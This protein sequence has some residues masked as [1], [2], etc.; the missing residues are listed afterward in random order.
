V[1]FLAAVFWPNISNS[2][3]KKK[4]SQINRAG[5]SNWLA[6]CSRSKDGGQGRSIDV[7]LVRTNYFYFYFQKDARSITDRRLQPKK[8]RF[9]ALGLTDILAIALGLQLAAS[10]M[11]CVDGSRLLFPSKKKTC[12][13]NYLFSLSAP[14]PNFLPQ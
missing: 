6:Q 3:V 8:K 10:V 13:W 7:S 4:K 1:A 5:G 11:S 9:C 12:T 14:L 2:R